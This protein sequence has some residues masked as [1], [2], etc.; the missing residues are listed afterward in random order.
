MMGLTKAKST[1][2]PSESWLLPSVSHSLG[3]LKLQLQERTCCV[4][5]NDL[6][7]NYTVTSDLSQC[8]VRPAP[9][10]VTASF[11]LRLGAAVPLETYRAS[12]AQALGVEVEVTLA[13]W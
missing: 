6:F 13:S 7:L 1:C 4:K 9:Q 2:P 12:V 5:F 11:S 3:L 8:A 10:Q